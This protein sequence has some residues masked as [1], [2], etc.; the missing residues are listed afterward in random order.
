MENPWLIQR[1]K[2]DNN[3]GGTGIDAL[4]RFDYM[5]SAEFEFGALPKS[6]KRIRASIADYTQFQYSFK[7]YPAKVVTVCCKKEHADSVGEILEQL[8]D[9]SLR[10]KESVCL[11][12][13]VK[14]EPEEKYTD[15]WWDLT[16]DMFFWKFNPE[17]DLKF[18]DA[19][20]DFVNAE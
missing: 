20:H 7:N 13:Y 12:Y 3:K 5:G 17:F 6:L 1:A 4:L 2:F 16:N 8:S 14:S 9:N 10:L 11:H 15:F 18:K 19:L